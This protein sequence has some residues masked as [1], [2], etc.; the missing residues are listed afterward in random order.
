MRFHDRVFVEADFVVIVFEAREKSEIWICRPETIELVS[1]TGETL[2]LIG[3]CAQ[4]IHVQHDA[5][6]LGKQAREFAEHRRPLFRRQRTKIAHDHGD[7]IKRGI[8]LEVEIVRL[9]VSHVE[10]LSPGMLPRKLDG[11]R[12]KVDPAH[13]GTETREP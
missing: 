11:L 8:G 5:S 6:T 1:F 9:Q 13:F 12:G 4:R 3:K 2:L 7:E 10:P